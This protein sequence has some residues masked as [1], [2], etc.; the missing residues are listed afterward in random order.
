MNYL[1]AQQ[2]IAELLAEAL[3]DIRVTVCTD[4][5]D[6]QDRA[7]GQPEIFVIFN[8]DDVG[9]QADDCALLRQRYAAIYVVPGVLPDLERDGPVLYA[10]HKAVA[11]HEPPERYLG[12]FYRTGSMRPQTWKDQGLL[13]YGMLF[14]VTFQL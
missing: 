14:G 6:V 11:G 7:I 2:I 13:A 8:D 1:R 4:L 5:A 12:Q 3:P 10:M 9:D